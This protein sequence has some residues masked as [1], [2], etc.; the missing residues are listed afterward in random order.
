MQKNNL[1]TWKKCFENRY[2]NI[3]KY[4]K[5]GVEMNSGLSHVYSIIRN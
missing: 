4:I 3:A 2:G 5:C 1:R